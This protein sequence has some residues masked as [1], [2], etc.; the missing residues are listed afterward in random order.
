MAVRK[1]APA[2]T[3][4]TEEGALPTEELSTE[5]PSPEKLATPSVSL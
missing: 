4:E 1:K 2:K 5:L 3:T